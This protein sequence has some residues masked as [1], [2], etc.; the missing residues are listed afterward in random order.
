MFHLILISFSQQVL[1][2]ITINNVPNVSS[3]LGLK[4]PQI[5]VESVSINIK[6]VK[7]YFTHGKYVSFSSSSKDSVVFFNS[8]KNI[9]KE[10]EDNQFEIGLIIANHS[11]IDKLIKNLQ[12]DI[13]KQFYMM[14]IIS[15]KIYEKY[16]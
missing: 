15:G 12:I 11:M 16:K 2:Q 14:D 8:Q 9:T 4:N 1:S 3:E 13:D 6:L 7:S 5:F 10:I